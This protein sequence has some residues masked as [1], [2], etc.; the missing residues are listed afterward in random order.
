MSIKNNKP[1]YLCY[2]AS[3]GCISIMSNN[4]ETISEHFIKVHGWTAKE[5]K[6]FFA[7]EE[8]E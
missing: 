7:E 6:E 4:E 8:E 1:M 3:A 2:A 5:C